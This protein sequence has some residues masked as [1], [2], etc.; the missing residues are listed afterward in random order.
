MAPQRTIEVENVVQCA[1]WVRGLALALVRDEHEAEDLAQDAWVIALKHRAHERERWGAWIGTT[2]R[3]LAR[4]RWRG[5][6]RREARERDVARP[7]VQPG[8]EAL[9]EQL[10]AHESIVRALRALEEPYRETILLRYFEGLPPREIAAR[11]GVPVKTVDTR[12]YRGLAHLRRQLDQHHRGDREAW[13]ALLLPL[14]RPRD[15]AVAGALA[16]NSKLMIAIAAAAVLALVWVARDTTTKDANAELAAAAPMSSEPGA[17]PRLDEPETVPSRRVA[18]EAPASAVAPAPEPAIVPPPAAPVAIRGTVIDAGGAALA[19][20]PVSLRRPGGKTAIPGLETSSD[21][22][23]EFELPLP[24]GA[25]ELDAPSANWVVLLRPSVSS[26]AGAAHVLVLAARCTLAGEVIDEAGRRLGGAQVELEPPAGLRAGIDRVLDLCVS[27]PFR[28]DT[29]EG[30]AFELDPAPDLD[31]CVLRATL[32]GFEPGTALLEHGDRLGLRIVLERHARRLAGRVVNER[33]EPIEGALVALGSNRAD[34]RSSSD[35]SRTDA[36]GEFDL[37]LDHVSGEARILRALK[38]GLMPAELACAAEAP[39][40]EGGWPEPLELVLRGAP[41]AIEGVV[42]DSDGRTVA[43]ATIANLDA[44]RFGTVEAEWS[45]TKVSVGE[46]IEALLAGRSSAVGPAA[47]TDEHGRFR[48]GGLLP[49]AYRLSAFSSKTMQFVVSAPIEA[50]QRG[51]ELRFPEEERFEVIAGRVVGRSGI[52]IAHAHVWL[53]RENTP[54]AST[55]VRASDT[56]LSGNSTYTD[57]DGRFEYRGVPR[58]VSG[59]HA[60][61]AVQTPDAMVALDASTDLSDVRIVVPLECH[62]KVD[63]TGTSIQATSVA[64]VDGDGQALSFGVHRGSLWMTRNRFELDGPVT[65]AFTV[66]EDAALVVL[67]GE[68]GELARI[69]LHLVPGE[70]VIVRP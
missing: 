33:Y 51:V 31:G 58:A 57:A 56:R 24:E 63:L 50:G 13:V 20:V 62:F 43:G 30:G 16:V 55:S 44:T 41:L 22:L 4:A 7:E 3:N 36:S 15:L 60:Q 1:E 34:S 5:E 19:G 46:D 54:P 26:K 12:L 52:P 9:L 39:W 8:G 35:V 17:P 2:L 49:R 14:I 27:E 18:I 61:A 28:T 11:A 29:D 53:E 42:L 40:M 47:S 23:G 69:P 25:A 66:S 21:A 68:G 38:A 65:E 67:S 32:Q 10:D 64:V 70:L 59:I 48:L 45:G 6:R 37:S